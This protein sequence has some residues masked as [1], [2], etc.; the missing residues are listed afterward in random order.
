[1]KTNTI[2]NIAIYGGSFDPPHIA[3]EEIIKLASSNLDIDRLF[4][5]PAYL[6]PLKNTNLFTPNQR[7]DLMK[8]VC[9]DYKN[10]IVDDYEIQND[11][12]T[13]TYDT[14]MHLKQQYNLDKIYLIIGEDNLAIWHKW[15]RYQE[16][17]EM[18]ELVIATRN[19]DIILKNDTKTLDINIDV[20]ST[21]LRHKL[22][23]KYIPKSIQDKISYLYQHLS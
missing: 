5:I 8:M 16:I 6:N 1:M 23:L 14:I 17:E 18:V 19:Q 3:H 15:Y 21:L 4:V 20:S 2:T 7:L 10:V 22:D 9:K 11:I 12:P 13:T